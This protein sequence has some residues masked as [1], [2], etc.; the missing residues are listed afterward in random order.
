[1]RPKKPLAHECPT[2]RRVIRWQLLY[3]V[4]CRGHGNP[5]YRPELDKGRIK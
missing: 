3:C 1:M 5:Q 4:D 2:C